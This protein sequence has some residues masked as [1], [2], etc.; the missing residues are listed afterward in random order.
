MVC[1]KVVK[2]ALI[3]DQIDKDGKDV[4]YNDIYKLLWDLQK[5]TREAKN[6]VIR[7]CWEWSGYSSEYFKT[8]EEYPKDKEIFGI[9]LRG[10]LYDRIKGDYNLYSGNLSQSAEITYKEYKNSLKDV[11]RGD[12]SIIN[13]REN[14]PLDIK[15][16][17]IQ[18][19]YEN[20][21]FFVRVALINKDKQKE[22]NF[23]DCSVR[24][25]LLVKDDSTRTILERCFDE[26]YTITASK[27]MYNKKKKQWYINLGYKFTKEIGKTLDK[28]RILGVDLGVIN[29]LVASVYGSYDRLIIGGG[30]IDKF[31]KRVE[32]NKV[33]MLKQGKYCGDGRIGHGVNTRNKPAYNIEDKIS[34]FRDTVNHKYS[35]A[36]VDYAVKN[37]CGTIQMEDLKGI[38]QNKN[39]RYLKN[40]TYFDLQTKIEY[41]AKALGIEVKYKNPKYTSQRCSKCGHIA[42]ENRP[43]QK[44]FKCVKCGFKVNADYNAS[45]NL[46]IKDIDK[47]IEQYYNKG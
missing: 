31:R 32:A 24:F 44:T 29:P 5:Q 4:N 45:Q 3:C 8:Y 41:K 33:Q 14:Q 37:N 26:V 6:K 17:A 35:K 46:A 39:E 12:K 40:W 34:R 25:K 23:K 36:V 18:L 27:I 43:E 20:D 7:L 1:N 19:L 38:T 9:S 30:E 47:I 28:D 21:N 22:L 11:L 2:I 16:K 42:E 10:Y 13:Y 15:N